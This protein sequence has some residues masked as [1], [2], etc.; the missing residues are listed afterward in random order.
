MA[1]AF[2]TPFA[3]SIA[4]ISGLPGARST[5]PRTSSTDSTFGIRFVFGCDGVFQIENHCVGARVED[6]TEQL[7]VMAGGEQLA[8]VHYNTPFA[9][10]AA[11]CSGSKPSDSR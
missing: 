7:L 2:A 4:Q 6:L 8:A 10:S 5:T 11:S 3:L 9:A 1:S